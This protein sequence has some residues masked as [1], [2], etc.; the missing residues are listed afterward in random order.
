MIIPRGE[1]PEI[2]AAENAVYEIKFK[3]TLLSSS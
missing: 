2:D 3:P 1:V